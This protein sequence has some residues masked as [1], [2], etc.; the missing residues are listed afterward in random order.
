MEAFNECLIN[1]IS[2]LLQVK[3]LI[4]GETQSLLSPVGGDT[5]LNQQFKPGVCSQRGTAPSAT[6]MTP[7]S[8]HSTRSQP[9]PAHLETIR[10]FSPCCVSPCSGGS[11][12]VP[13]HFPAVW[14]CLVLSHGLGGGSML[15]Q[16]GTDC[17]AS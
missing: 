17:P 1:T 7:T 8:F 6:P 10:N 2:V 4:S 9:F 3:Y 14:W 16:E 15:Q 13:Q 12:H 11:P 5:H